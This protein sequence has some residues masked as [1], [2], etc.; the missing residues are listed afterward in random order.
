MYKLFSFSVIYLTFWFTFPSSFHETVKRSSAL[1]TIGLSPG[2]NKGL[3]CVCIQIWVCCCYA[4]TTAVNCATLVVLAGDHT[5]GLTPSPYRK[6]V[7]ATCK[8]PCYVLQSYRPKASFADD[9][10]FCWPY[11]AIP[12]KPE[13][14]ELV[15]VSLLPVFHVSGFSC[16]LC[17]SI[18]LFPSDLGFSPSIGFLP[19]PFFFFCI[20]SVNGRYTYFHFFWSEK[21]YPALILFEKELLFNA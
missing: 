15:Q 13:W 6:M 17:N 18:F 9:V 7:P 2:Q 20:F 4:L 19:T 1:H 12:R 3:L 16:H 21:L 8:F 10:C 14:A 11:R 5:S